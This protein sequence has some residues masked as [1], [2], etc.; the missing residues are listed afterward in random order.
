MPQYVKIK[1]LPG[2][3]QI[4]DYYVWTL[5]TNEHYSQISVIVAPTVDLSVIRTMIKNIF[6]ELATNA[7]SSVT[8][9][10]VGS[11]DGDSASNIEQFDTRDSSLS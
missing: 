1:R 4:T 6:K 10:A 11:I 9:F 3:Y 2:V 7:P 8:Q 5:C